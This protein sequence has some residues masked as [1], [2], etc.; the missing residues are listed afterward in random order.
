MARVNAGATAPHSITPAIVAEWLDLFVGPDDVAEL[1]ALQ[2]SQRYG[3]PATVAGF[4]DGQH[5]ADMATAALELTEQCRGVYLTMNPLRREILA[6]CANRTKK[7]EQGDLASDQHV[8]CRRWLLL[9]IDPVRVAGIGATDAEKAAAREVADAV[10]RDLDGRG[11]PAPILADSGN[12]WHLFYRLDLPADDGEVVKRCLA[13]L[14]TRHDTAAAKVDKSVCNAARIVK[15]PGTAARKG[16]PTDDRPHRRGGILEIPEVLLPVSAELLKA[17]ADDATAG[18]SS[19]PPNGKPAAPATS[20]PDRNGKAGKHRLDVPRWL[21]DRGIAFR[22]RDTTDA[23]GRTVY[24]LDSCPFNSDHRDA[25]VLQCDS[26]KLAFHCF[27]DS[28]AGRSWQAAKETIGKPDPDHYDPPLRSKNSDDEDKAGGSHAVLLVTLALGAAELF[29][30]GETAYVTIANTATTFPMASRAFRQLLARWF[31]LAKR[32]VPSGEALRA[33]LD[34]LAGKALFEGPSLPVRVRLA[35]LHGAIYLDLGREDW[36]AV[37]IT[38]NGWDVVTRYPVRFKHPRGMLPLPLPQRGQGLARLREL[39]NLDDTGWRLVLGWLLAAF[40]PSGP[41]PVLILTGEQGAAKST[42]GKVLRSLIDPNAAPLRSEP[43]DARDVVIAAGNSWVCAL[44][45]LSYLPPWLSD[46]LCRLATG[47]GFAT[48]AL[49]TDADE[50]IFDSQRPI[51]LTS[52]EDVAERGD[53]LDRAV[54]VRLAAIPEEKRRTEAEYWAAAAAARPAILAALLD[55]VAAGIRNLPS[56]RLDR[57]PRMAD[58]ALWVSACEPALDWP[59]GAFMAAYAGNV[60]DANDLALDASPLWPALRHLMEH[61]RTWQGSAAELL[62]EL[63]RV[64]GLDGD[65]PKR[66]KGWP[67]APHAL[68]GRLRRLAPNMRRAGIDMAFHR[69][70]KHRTIQ[71][72]TSLADGASQTSQASPD[73]QNRGESA[74]PSDAPPPVGDASPLPSDASAGLQDNGKQ[75]KVTPSDACDASPATFAADDDSE[76]L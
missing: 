20:A 57:L 47:G 62:K 37:R 74:R 27:H 63:E 49:F 33:A 53:L 2:V 15:V 28:C 71:L 73:T 76:L 44:D 45:N 34:T 59:A 12:G 43:R 17:L 8:A 23:R 48:R 55:A 31:F 61:R 69:S 64:V 56:V 14:A 68:T 38:A 52:I 58:F 40:R 21:S 36:S 70:G 18:P 50:V 3:R 19:S 66:P 10:R 1:R 42:T 32:R 4:F 5:L 30:D 24:A 11:W 39:L 75:A 25:A 46:C 7:A 41:Y 65:A 13:A 22:E 29:H 72:A 60:A 35:E 54:I 16:D 9:D 6:R 67:G 26:G 51:I